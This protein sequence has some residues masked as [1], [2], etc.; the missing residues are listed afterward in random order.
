MFKNQ[1]NNETDLEA[2][3]KSA[4]DIFPHDVIIAVSDS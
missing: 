1:G 2:T 4:L 3:V